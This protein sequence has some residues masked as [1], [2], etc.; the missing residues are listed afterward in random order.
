MRRIPRLKRR[1]SVDNNYK[2]MLSSI[3]DPRWLKHHSTS[4]QGRVHWW[5]HCGPC[6]WEPFLLDSPRCRQ[7][8][9]GSIP[10]MNS[11]CSPSQCTPCLRPVAS[12]QMQNYGVAL[13][14]DTCP[15][16]S[17]LTN[18]SQLWGLWVIARVDSS[19]CVCMLCVSSD[20]I[21]QIVVPYNE[22]NHPLRRH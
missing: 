4:S 7:S 2:T 18:N 1:V 17:R 20:N 15:R 3:R 16:E 21:W 6:C 19:V 8:S 5:T 22:N 11:D 10:L 12:T 13:A 9:L 14:Y